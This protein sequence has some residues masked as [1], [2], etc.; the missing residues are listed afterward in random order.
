MFAKDLGKNKCLTDEVIFLCVIYFMIPRNLPPKEI[1]I[2][3]KFTKYISYFSLYMGI[4][5][6]FCDKV[7]AI[8][9]YVSSLCL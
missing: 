7:F 9:L 8:K 4:R 3:L 2:K 6:V 1:L 5:D